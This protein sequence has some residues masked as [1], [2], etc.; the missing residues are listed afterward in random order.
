MRKQV[1]ANVVRSLPALAPRSL[2]TG[3]CYKPVYAPLTMATFSELVQQMKLL[4][5][6]RNVELVA[7]L[8][9]ARALA[10]TSMRREMAEWRRTQAARRASEHIA[11][12]SA[13]DTAAQQ[14]AG[15]LHA[16]VQA[17]HGRRARQT[18]RAAAR[19]AAAATGA[20]IAAEARAVRGADRYKADRRAE[21]VLQAQARQKWLAGLDTQERVYEG[22]AHKI[23]A[24]VANAAAVRAAGYTQEVHDAQA[25]EWF[26]K[27][28]RAAQL[29]AMRE[30]GQARVGSPGG[31]WGAGVPLESVRDPFPMAFVV[32]ASE[33]LPPEVRLC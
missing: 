20:A 33:N 30:A 13:I 14:R 12:N 3:H 29:K 10:F 25:D 6:Q 18:G 21:A 2:K 1:I 15:A 9:Q 28:A 5:K 23:E 26:D 11:A 27:Q 17:A 8:R 31:V 32:A 19:A 22:R 4:W 16:R 7:A 24:N